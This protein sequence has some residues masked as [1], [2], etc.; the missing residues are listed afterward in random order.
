[1]GTKANESISEEQVISY[2]FFL[3]KVHVLR[4]KQDKI[5]LFKN[6]ISSPLKETT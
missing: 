4:Q 2:S 6:N 1:M 5:H 3:T